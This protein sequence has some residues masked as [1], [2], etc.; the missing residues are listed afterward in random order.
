M[1]QLQ[2]EVR[3]L[4]NCCIMTSEQR[5]IQELLLAEELGDRTPSQVLRRIRQLLGNMVGPHLAQRTLS[6]TSTD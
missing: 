2:S 3:F 1:P 5:C 6:P 4:E